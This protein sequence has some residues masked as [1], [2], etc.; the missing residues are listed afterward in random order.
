MD[1]PHV[2]RLAR[3]VILVARTMAVGALVA[4]ATSLNGGARDSFTRVVTCAADRVSVVP[5]PDIKPPSSPEPQ[6]P[7]EAAGPGGMGYWEQRR[8]SERRMSESPEADC[9]TFEVTG[10]DQRI[11][12]CCR[13]PWARDS[14]GVLAVRTDTVDCQRRSD[15]LSKSQGA[16]PPPPSAPPANGSQ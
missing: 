8:K 1:R 16:A 10:C 2:A 14:T 3:S 4:C 12:F 13:H 5:R 6:S 15:D 7:D 11:L 9:E